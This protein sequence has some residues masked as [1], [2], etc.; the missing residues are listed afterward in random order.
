MLVDD[1]ITGLWR[2]RVEDLDG[3]GAGKVAG[4]LALFVYGFSGGQ[5]LALGIVDVAG[6]EQRDTQATG[7]VDQ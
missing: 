6:V 3:A 2:Q 4:W 5:V 1:D 7:G